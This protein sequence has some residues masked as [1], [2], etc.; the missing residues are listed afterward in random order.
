[1][2]FSRA[3]RKNMDSAIQ[4]PYVIVDLRD[5]NHPEYYVIP[6]QD[7][8]DITF[9]TDDAYYQKKLANGHPDEKYPIAVNIKEVQAYKDILWHFITAIIPRKSSHQILN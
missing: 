9:R 6:K 5:T 4:G 3:T 1:M 8:K 7:L 2:G